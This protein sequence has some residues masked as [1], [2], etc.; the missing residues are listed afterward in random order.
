MSE[1]EIKTFATILA[2]LLVEAKSRMTR[3][4][5]WV[6]GGVIHSILAVCAKGLEKLYEA[7]QSAID[8][9]FLDTAT[10]VW[11]LKIAVLIGVTRQEALKARYNLIFYRDE[12]SAED[13]DIPAGALAGTAQAE[14]GA[15]FKYQV[16]EDAVLPAGE[17]EVE[18]LIEAYAA[19]ASSNVG[20][21]LINQLYS[22][23]PGID[24][25]K[26]DQA[27]A[28]L[29]REGADAES[30]DRLKD[31]CRNRWASFSYG[32]TREAYIYHALTADPSVRR[33]SVNALAPRGDGTVDV[34]F[35]TTSPDGLP[36]PAVIAI[37]QI[38]IDAVK[39]C[40]ADVLAKGPTPVDI[41]LHLI[42]VQSLNGGD[43]AV[44]ADAVETAAENL[45][46][47][48][49]GEIIY[50]IGDD[51]SR[52]KIFAVCMPVSFVGNL[53]IVSPASDTPVSADGL[54]RLNSISVEVT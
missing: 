20:Q 15:V 28:G 45:F 33:V 37:V 9:A 3:I 52:G 31:R 23:I 26:N 47:P 14:D 32:G 22:S 1:P 25:V 51:G 8:L 41:D 50:N 16:L 54:A 35:T 38:A 49:D 46:L 7:L 39:P 18:V 44:I 6:V 21:G 10:G 29:V 17:T 27:D 19:G 11:L 42:A 36:T 34:I 5:N 4:T 12:A 48:S 2:E 24:G 40:E 13:T 53:I 43:A 30:E